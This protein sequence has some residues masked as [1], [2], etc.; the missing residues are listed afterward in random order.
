MEYIEIDTST[1]DSIETMESIEQ[2]DNLSRG[3]KRRMAARTKRKSKRA[4]RK[5]ARKSMKAPAQENEQETPQSATIGTGTEP[6]ESF[7]RGSGGLNPQGDTE[8][9]TVSNEPSDTDTG[10]E[11]DIPPT[12]DEEAGEPSEFDHLNLKKAFG[13]IKGGVKNLVKKIG[14]VAGSA[15]LLPLLPLKPLIKKILKQKK[16]STAGSLKDLVNRFYNGVVKKHPAGKNYDNIDLDNYDDENSVDAIGLVVGAIIDFIKQIKKKKESGAK[17]T[18]EEETIIA[19]TDKVTK[20][21]SEKAKSEAAAN[22][23]EKILFDRKTQFIIIGVVIAIIIV[24][25]MVMRGMKK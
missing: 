17:M 14:S 25:L 12:G 19:G 21:L 1:F 8:P 5:A 18:K 20:K 22:I 2:I 24:V 4:G 13:K 6:A 11:N 16:L 15:V 23:G 7:P 10:E 3:K 9:G